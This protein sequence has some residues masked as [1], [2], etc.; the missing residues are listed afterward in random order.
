MPITAVLSNSESNQVPTF[1]IE[2]IGTI[3]LYFVSTPFT[4]AICCLSLYCI[5]TRSSITSLKDAIALLF[6][7]TCFCSEEKIKDFPF[8]AEIFKSGSE[9][10]NKESLNVRKPENPER[11]IKSA[12]E[13][14]ITPKV[15]IMVII[16]IA[17]FPLLANK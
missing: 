7:K 5:K 3:L 8:T 4:Y 12:K 11:I 2:S 13:P 1:K 10:S 14:T 16:L 15:A 17:L 9:S 6:N